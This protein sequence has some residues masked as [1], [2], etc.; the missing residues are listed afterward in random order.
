MIS[1]SSLSIGSN[2]VCDTISD[3]T[4]KLIQYLVSLASL[5]AI[6]YLE[7]KSFVDCAYTASEQFAPIDVPDRKNCLDKTFPRHSRAIVMRKA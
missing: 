5:R 1:S 3:L 6:E 7:I 4:I 2:L